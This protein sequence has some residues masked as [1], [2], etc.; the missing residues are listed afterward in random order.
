M[1]YLYRINNFLYLWIN[2]RI[3]GY[4]KYVNIIWYDLNFFCVL[5]FYKRNNVFLFCLFYSIDEG[6][7]ICN[8]VFVFFRSYKDNILLLIIML[9]LLIILLENYFKEVE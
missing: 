8:K 6:N 9:L 1:K 3:Y 5:N 4:R 2:I 7:E